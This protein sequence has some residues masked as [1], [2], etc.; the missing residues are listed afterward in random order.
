MVLFLRGGYCFP[1]TSNATS[2]QTC[3]VSCITLHPRDINIVGIRAECLE[4]NEARLH[5]TT[6]EKSLKDGCLHKTMQ[7]DREKHKTNAA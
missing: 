3:P 5:G 1:L 6:L 4:V 7:K 2:R